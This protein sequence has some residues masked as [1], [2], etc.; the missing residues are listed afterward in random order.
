MHV[1]RCNAF[2]N[3]PAAPPLPSP[4]EQLVPYSDKASAFAAA[5]GLYK[6]PLANREYYFLYKSVPVPAPQ[7]SAP[8]VQEWAKYRVAPRLAV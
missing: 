5:I 6:G 7:T 2:L 4:H 1:Q 8:A 3:A